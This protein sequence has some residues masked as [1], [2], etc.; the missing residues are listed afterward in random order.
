MLKNLKSPGKRQRVAE[1]NLGGCTSLPYTIHN[2]S[3]HSAA[4]HPVHIIKNNPQD[5][6]SRW[7]SAAN[8]QNQFII[9]KFVGMAVVKQITFGKYYKAHVCNLKEF[10]VFG[11]VDLEGEEGP[12]TWMELL[13]GGLRNDAEPE[14]FPLRHKSGDMVCLLKRWLTSL[15][16]S[17]SLHQ[18]CANFAMGPKLQLFHLARCIQWTQQCCICK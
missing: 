16:V 3:S 13:H 1:N 2:F 7:S 15:A 4:Y 6:A 14:T 10:K 8:D 12:G 17:L 18:D 11:A 5:Q 9:V